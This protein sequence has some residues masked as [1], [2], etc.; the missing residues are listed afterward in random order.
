MKNVGYKAKMK[1]HSNLWNN[2]FLLQS[3]LTTGHLNH[4]ET[5]TQKTRKKQQQRQQNKNKNKTKTKNKTKQKKK[6]LYINSVVRYCMYLKSTEDC[7]LEEIRTDKHRAYKVTLNLYIAIK[8]LRIY[9]G[10]ARKICHE[11]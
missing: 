10:Q 11:Y 3:I 5:S 2:D 4:F 1:Y 8:H 9:A 6:H 7:E